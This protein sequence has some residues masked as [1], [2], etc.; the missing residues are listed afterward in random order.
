M[1]S[2][3]KSRRLFTQTLVLTVSLLLIL[4]IAVTAILYYNSQNFT[5]KAIAQ[6]E[7]EHN[8]NLMRQSNI[9]FHQIIYISH[10]LTN[11]T[12]PY[13]ALITT[14]N[15]WT[16]EVFDTMLESHIASN[17]YISSIDVKLGHNSTAPSILKHEQQIG[18]IY[19]SAIWGEN[20]PVWPYYF[21]IVAENTVKKNQVTLTL[22]GYRLS[23]CIFTFNDKN[24]LE[25]LL[26]PNGTVLLTNQRNTFFRDI[27]ELHP[28]IL[29]TGDTPENTLGSYSNYYYMY[30]KS[31]KYAFGILTLVPKSTYSN[32][33]NSIL[34]QAFLL[35]GCLILAT[36][37]I[38]LFLTIRFYRPIKSTVDLLQTYI[39][40]DLH[41]YENEIV[42][43]Q[44]Q[45][46]RYATPNKATETS[47]SDSVSQIQTAQVAVL[48]HQINAHFLFNTLENI[49]AISIAELGIKNEIETSILLLNTIIREGVFQKKIFVPLSYELHLAKCY[50]ELMA[51]RFADVDIRWLLDESL[52]DCQVF[53]FSL[54]PILENCF[55]HAFK[56]NSGRRKAI[57]ISTAR[58][59]T[60]FKI[61]ICDNGIGLDE[62][63]T[64]QA[65]QLLRASGTTESASHVGIR[66]IH[67]R[68]SETF[69]HDYGIRISSSDHGTAVEIKYP[70][71]VTPPITE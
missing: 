14:N 51:L 40:D 3:L 35:A 61:L 10:C 29:L 4:C 20:Q 8:A 68:I 66:N 12:V 45:I 55:I 7:A 2:W 26:L 27:T 56:G 60:D 13:E 53:K 67:K 6:T 22:S 31:E 16:R 38:S 25:Y 17:D 65:N 48:Q 11:M 34:L 41:E 62:A 52:S 24:R 58:C 42:F 33:Y 64:T 59:G 50:L 54:Q 37:M 1:K 30:T 39:P 21:D 9:Y 32:Q 57:E 44:Q 18:S 15:F 19:N 36:A 46:V 70:Q 47:I 71:V 23:E 63:A 5:D 49:K 69:G 28:G 43:I